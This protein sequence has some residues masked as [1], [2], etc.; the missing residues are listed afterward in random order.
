MRA[1]D[2]ASDLVQLRQAQLVGAVDD[3]GVRRRHVDAAF[4][5]GGA[6]QDVEALVVEIQHHLFQLFLRH[7]PVGDFDLCIRHQLPDA[8]CDSLYGLDFVVKEIDLPAAFDFTQAGFGDQ[9]VVPF[10]D[11]GVDGMPL[12]GR[13]GDD[14][15]VAHA[16]Q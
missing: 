7:L 14:G 11:K 12:Q 6:H 8:V 5:D 3:D 9:L 1:A 4:D 10:G 2:A 13:G 15:K 16:G